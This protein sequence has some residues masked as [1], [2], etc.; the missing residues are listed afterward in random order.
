MTEADDRIAPLDIARGA[1]IMGVVLMNVVAITLPQTLNIKPAAGGGIGDALIWLAGFVLVDGKARALLAMLFGASTLLV[2]D[3]AEMDGRDGISVQRRR[4]FWLIPIG[5]AHYIFLWSGD[6]LMLLGVGG[7]IA[8]RF[9]SSEPFDL[10]KAAFLF[11]A[12]QLL[13]VLFS[14]ASAY[15]GTTPG[16][17]HAL[18][19]RE[20][21]LDIGLHREGYG[22]ILMERIMHLPQA[23]S[24]LVI[25]ALPETMGF[26]ML[27]MAMAKGGFFFGQWT[28]EQYRQSTRRAYLVGIPPMLALGL[29]AMLTDDPRTQ[30]MIGYAASFPFRIPLTIGHAALL[31]MAAEGVQRARLAPVA[32]VG[33]LALSN[34]LLC[35][36]VM[37]SLAYGYGAGLYA[38]IGRPGL[39][40]IAL[41]LLTF[42]VFWSRLW[43]ARVGRGPAEHMWRHMQR[44]GTK[45]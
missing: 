26:M 43:L 38:H 24:Q 1:A 34:Y 25:H 31:V 33:R 36:L 30:D 20:M 21:V 15:W 7:L 12:A 3:R 44:L 4:L 35:S 14:A 28:P 13:L 40:G 29:W 18:L 16:G 39:L 8:L 9:V 17:Y 5:L 19:Q 6:I 11:F 45:A 37:T 42:I 22:A 41:L 10:V 32:A 27:G 2:I 23:A